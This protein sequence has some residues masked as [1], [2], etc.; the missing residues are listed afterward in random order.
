MTTLSP[1]L[2]P[3]QEGLHVLFHPGPRQPSL[4]SLDPGVTNQLPAA[5]QPLPALRTPVPSSS[6]GPHSEGSPLPIPTPWLS[7]PAAHP[8]TAPAK[9]PRS[10]PVPGLPLTA[11]L[12]HDGQCHSREGTGAWG[13][14]VE[15]GRGRL[16]EEWP[17]ACCT[18]SAP[19][20]HT[21]LPRPTTGTVSTAN[22]GPGLQ[23]RL[24]T[25]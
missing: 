9:C 18:S 15:A 11:T 2:N 23:F 12:S 20:P 19:T 22:K 16:C 3:P 13:V 14:M 4:R 24:C 6:C 1:V 25:L 10:L 17:E 21:L 8:D 7:T 5:P